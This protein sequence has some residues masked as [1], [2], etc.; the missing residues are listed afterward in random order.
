MMHKRFMMDNQVKAP[1][2]YIF[3]IVLSLFPA[4]A[5]GANA[6]KYLTGGNFFIRNV[7][8][9]D[10]LGN[11]PQPGQ[12]LFISNG[13]IA[14][15]TRAGENLPPAG[16]AVIEGQDLTVMPGLID[17]HTHIRSQWHGGL[18]LQDKYPQT[19]EHKPLQ[20]NLA[21]YLYAGVTGIFN[22]G[23]A[24]VYVVRGYGTNQAVF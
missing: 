12:D 14:A 20:Q 6:D 17:A 10:G 21:A 15:I 22:V 1:L 24:T 9:V 3:L 4:V 5:L 7:T 8:V 13:K 19:R 16:A 11:P 2:A 18:V 23:D